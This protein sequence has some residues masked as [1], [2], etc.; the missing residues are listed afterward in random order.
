MSRRSALVEQVRGEGMPQRVWR[1]V[2]NIGALLDV[3]IDHS[4]DARVVIRV[5]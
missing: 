4:A 3:L 2:V 5:P 1:D